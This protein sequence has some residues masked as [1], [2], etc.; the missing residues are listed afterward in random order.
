MRRIGLLAMFV[1]GGRGR[2]RPGWFVLSYL[3]PVISFF[4]VGLLDALTSWGGL[5]RVLW[6]GSYFVPLYVL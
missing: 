6:F 2:S 4:A 5:V 3:T 1:A